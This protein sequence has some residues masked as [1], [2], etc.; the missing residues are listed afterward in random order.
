MTL[1][2]YEDAI[3]TIDLPKHGLLGGDAGVVVAIPAIAPMLPQTIPVP[4]LSPAPSCAFA[5][6][7]PVSAVCADGLFDPRGRSGFDRAS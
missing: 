3:L 7:L 2:M 5:A 1:D 6:I 4:V